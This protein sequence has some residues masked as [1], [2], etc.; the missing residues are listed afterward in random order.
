MDSPRSRLRLLSRAASPLAGVLMAFLP[1][2][3]PASSAGPDLDGIEFFETH[4]RPL[5]I[6]SCYS[7]HSAGA[8]KVRGDLLLDS[9]AGWEKGGVSGNPSIRPGDPDASPLIQAVRHE[10]DD[11]AMPP[12]KKLPD[13]HIALLEAWVRMGAP[14]PRTDGEALPDPA[15]LAAGHWAFQ[16]VRTPELPEVS[17]VSWVRNGIDRFILAGIEKAGLTPAPQADRF[18]LIRRASFVLTGLPP[19]DE[20]VAAFEADPSPDAFEQVVDRLLASPRYGERW[21]RHWLDVARYA[22]TKGY[23]FEEE[24]R[25]PYAYTYRDY[26]VRAFNDDKPYDQFLLEQIAAD[27]VVTEDDRTALAAMGFLTLGRRFLNNA[28]DIIDDRIDVLTRG[29]MALTVSCAR[30]HDHKYDPIP[31]A[32]YYSLYGVFASSEEPA[33]KPLLGT[34]PDAARHAEFA[35]ELSRRETERDEFVRSKEE[36][37]RAKLRRTVGTHLL[38]AHDAAAFEDAGKREEIARSRQLSPVVVNRWIAA[39]EGWRQDP[40]PL[41]AAW[42]AFAALPSESFADDAAAVAAA[43]ASPAGASGH[44]APVVEAFAGDPPTSLKEVAE[45]YDRLFTDPADISL[46]DFLASENAP[47]ALSRGE[48]HRLFDVPEGQR[49]RALQRAVEQLQATHPGAPPRAMALVDKSRPVE[50]VVFRRGNPGNRGDTVPRQF[51][52]LLSGPERQPFTQGS[53][54]LELARAIASPDNPLTARVAVNRAWI[55]HFGAGLV[56]TPGDFGLRADPPTHPK[57]LDWLAAS[58]VAEGWSMKALHRLI[59]HSATWQQSGHVTPEAAV[60]DPDNR[61]LSHQNR[62]RLDFEALRDMLLQASGQLD[63]TMGGHAV[64][65]AA[66]NYQP[67]RTVYGF[68]ERQNLPGVFR[69][70]DFASPDTTSAQRFQ[71]TVPQQALFFMNS[72][73]VLDQARHLVRRPEVAQAGSVAER[74]TQLYRVVFQRVPDAGEIALAEHFLAAAGDP[75]SAEPVPVWQYGHGTWDAQA[76][77]V[78]NFQPLPHFT[79]STWQGGP[80]LPD[81]TLG[82]ISLSAEGGHPGSPAHGPA[83]RRW[84]APADGLIEIRGTLRHPGEAGDGVRALVVASRHGL[85]GQ[86]DVHKGSTQTGI[87]GI[88]VL[89]GDHIDFVVE[90]R[91]DEHTD[92]FRWAPRL[93]DLSAAE[94]GAPEPSWDARA[95]FEGPSGTTRPLTPWER[96]GQVLL[97]ANE[98][99]FVD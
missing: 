12:R 1:L 83:I 77:E 95:D 19:T 21:G 54:R 23:V 9:K 34:I 97:M 44:P 5:L 29:T 2:A 18:T 10:D 55:H 48:L 72:P 39:V 86:W 25:Y 38:A 7:C 22:D 60:K 28:H 67:R 14:D 17:D 68:V 56:R 4:I 8:D 37:H 36:E 13:E 16:P 31:T 89:R 6:D 78:R 84:T 58:F 88:R 64:E 41:F 3:T 30:C 65:I 35:A 40:N 52:E 43:I 57:L 82:W 74:V 63:L 92:S 50:P 33:E 75:P 90:C 11:L 93:R 62:R 80:D 27:A 15:Q 99:M 81:P 71:T 53:G 76:Q 96:Y 46:K 45:R 24:R 87:D 32:D 79:G 70:F 66:Q 59:L 73:F 47:I 85:L 98:A 91:A 26:V 51:L 69:T 42:L 49:Q 61:L 20:E 94:S